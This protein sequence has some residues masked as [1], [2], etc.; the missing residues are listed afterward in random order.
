MSSYLNIYLVKAKTEK[1]NEDNKPILFDYYSR[2]S[3]VYQTLNEYL[4]I[5]YCSD[6]LKYKELSPEEMNEVL[7]EF[8][9]D[10][11]KA[12]QIL[13]VN[14]KMLKE[15]GSLS[16]LWE[17]IQQGERYIEELKQTKESLLFI[18]HIVDNCH[19]DYTGFEKVLI[20]IE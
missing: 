13:K 11:K 9:V 10:I 4:N 16:T 19:L 20:N 14:Y 17:E 5:P 1:D 7:N 6:E 18:K 8:E 12:K 15:G 3:E 2:S